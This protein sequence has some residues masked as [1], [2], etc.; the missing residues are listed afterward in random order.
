MRAVVQ[1]VAR[2]EV[3]VAGRVTGAIGLGVLALLGVG[4]DDEAADAAW[5]A[6]K[7]A[8]LRIFSDEAGLMNRS[9]LVVG[10]AILLV[11]QFTLYGDARKGRRPSFVAAA[12]GTRAQTLYELVGRTLAARGLAVS[13]GEFGADMDVELLNRGPVTLLIDSKRNF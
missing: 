4:R 5:I 8:T 7:I 13:Y 1:R 6:E 11:S 10:G 2:A 9:V 12:S 3:R